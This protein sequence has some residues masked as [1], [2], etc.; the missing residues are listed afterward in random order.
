MVPTARI[1]KS[2]IAN[3]LDPSI[4]ANDHNNPER[5]ICL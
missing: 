2:Q 3:G 1:R 5:D 4:Q